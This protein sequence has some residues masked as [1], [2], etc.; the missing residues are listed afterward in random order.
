MIGVC[1]TVGRGCFIMYW[2]THTLM[3]K[4]YRVDAERYRERAH[5]GRVPRRRSNSEQWYLV[6]HRAVREPFAT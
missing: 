6:T 1:G 5:V 3:M 4:A 2:Y